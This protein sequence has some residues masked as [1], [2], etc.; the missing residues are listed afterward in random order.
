[1]AYQ[2]ENIDNMPDVSEEDSL[3][4]PG[5]LSEKDE[6]YLD[7]YNRLIQQGFLSTLTHQE[8]KVWRL[9]S[10]TQASINEIAE[11]LDLSPSMIRKYI[12]K[13][14]NKLREELAVEHDW[15]RPAEQKYSRTGFKKDL[16]V[17]LS[18]DTTRKSALKADRL[19]KERLKAHKKE[20]DAFL[21][22][23]PLIRPKCE[24]NFNEDN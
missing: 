14:T 12:K 21:K 20:V 24:D 1:M 7:S 18:R 23:H 6:K 4:K 19:F 5:Q 11:E 8:Y 3:L 13:V 22:T 2:E 10:N 9:F 16:K 15:S 17:V